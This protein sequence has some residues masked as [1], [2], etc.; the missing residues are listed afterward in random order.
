MRL[1]DL[2]Q[3]LTYLQEAG[4]RAVADLRRA[5]AAIADKDPSTAAQLNRVA[6]SIEDTLNSTD[7]TAITATALDELKALVLSGKSVVT[8][9]LTDIV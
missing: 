3:A 4:K 9:Q 6:D 2:L 8:H 5:A 7:F 1:P